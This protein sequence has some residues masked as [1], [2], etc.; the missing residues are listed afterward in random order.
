M[1]KK[2]YLIGGLG[3]LLIGLIVALVFALRRDNRSF[4][5]QYAAYMSY[6]E[7]K[8][9]PDADKFDKELG[10]L[11]KPITDVTA[12]YS[13]YASSYEQSL[14]DFGKDHPLTKSELSELQ[15]AKAKLP[16]AKANLKVLENEKTL[17]QISILMEAHVN[18]L[19]AMYVDLESAAK[20]E[21]RIK[22]LP[23]R[24]GQGRDFLK[25]RFAKLRKELND[26]EAGLKRLGI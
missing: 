18:K 1:N 13:V 21:S 23:E 11:M 14:K 7:K 4:A 16:E 12:T 10:F 6:I 5:E 26:A 22:D 15:D 2:Y 3:L 8:I 25:R 24:P 9:K 19:D 20:R 17:S